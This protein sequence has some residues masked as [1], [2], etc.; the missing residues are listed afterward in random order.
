MSTVG[1]N[2]YIT[3]AEY[4]AYAAERNITV[5][6]PNLDFDIIKSADFINLYYTLQPE[7]MLPTTDTDAITAINK[8]ALKACELQQA[9]RL[10][11]DATVLAG[12]LVSSV[13]QQLEGVGQVS[14]T[15]E[16]GSQV[17][18]KPRVPELDRLLQPFLLYGSTGLKRG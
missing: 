14:T 5:D 11:L 15:Y 1:T 6:T 4:N 18:Y 3:A 10:A 17:T 2:A 8:A 12:G 16:S 7:Y 9:G 13:S